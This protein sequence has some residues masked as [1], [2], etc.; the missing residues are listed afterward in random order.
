MKNFKVFLVISIILISTLTTFSQRK[1]SGKIVEVIDGKTAVVEIGASAKLKVVLQNIETP[2][3]EQPLHGVVKEHLEKFML[4]KTA[5]VY[6][7]GIVNSVTVAQVFVDGVDVSQQM[8]RDGAAW[9]ALP[10]KTDKKTV[11]SEIYLS[12]EA[13]AKAEKRGVWGIEGLK[14]AWEFR[15]AKQQRERAEEI[16]RFEEIRKQNQEKYQ[17]T[18]KKKLPPPPAMFSNFEMWKAGRTPGMWDE[19]QLYMANQ[20]FDENGLFIYKVPQ[21]NI[22]F[23]ITKD[24]QLNLSSGENRPKIVCGVAYVTGKSK[25]EKE[26][27]EFFGMGCRSESDK[28]SFKNSNQLTFS[29]DGKKMNFGKT[30]H[31]G[32]QTDKR[33]NEMMVFFLDRNSVTKIAAA[34][35][36][37]VKIGDFSGDIPPNFHSMIKHLVIES[38]NEMNQNK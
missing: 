18:E 23:V 16:V 21:N 36:V 34:N 1:L 24:V 35:K 19:M 32:M 37:H 27:K 25:E 3:P 17:R 15:A 11:E 38:A 5:V 14:P 4:G 7:K 31:L 2:E 9:Y 6:P 13:H 12:N 8:L 22:A 29:T 28:L 10:E 26:E 30:I 20:K 33:F